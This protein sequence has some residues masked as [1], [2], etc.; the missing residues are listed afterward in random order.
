M[1]KR[2]ISILLFSGILV[3]THGQFSGGNGSGVSI[4]SLTNNAC[5]YLTNDALMI[6]KGGNG[7]GIAKVNMIPNA[8]TYLTDDALMIFKGGNGGGIA[9]VNMIPNACTFTQDIGVLIF[10]GGNGSGA[11]SVSISSTACP[12]PEANNIFLGGISSSSINGTVINTASANTTGPFI[13]TINDTTIANGNC[14]T[15]TTTGTGANTFSWT[16][17]VGLSNASTQNPIANPTETTTY[18]VTATGPSLGC[19]DVAKVTIKV[20]GAGVNTTISYPAKVCTNV[21]TIQSP[22]LT[23]ITGGTFTTTNS[24]LKIDAITGAITPNTSSVGVYTVTYTYGTCNNQVTTSVEITNDC[25]T[26]IGVIEFPN[27]YAGGSAALLSP[28]SSLVQGACTPNLDYTQLIYK[29][30][31]A[32]NLTPKSVLVQLACPIPVGDNFYLGGAGVGYGNGSLTPTTNT[33]TGTAVAVSADI[34]ICPGV[35]TTLSATGASFYS[36]T[37]SAGLSNTTSANPIASPSTTTT[38]TVLGSG[39]GVGC[40]NTAKVTVT[41]IADPSTTVSYGGYNFDEEDLNLK[42]V[43]YIN[44]PLTGTFSY[45]PTGLS[46]NASDG[47]FTPGLS[48]SGIYAINYAYTKGACSYVATTNI[49]ITKLPPTITYTNPAR[50]Y[51][52]YNG[53]TLTPNITG[54]TAVIFEILDVLPTGLTFNTLTGV[55]SGTP[56]QLVDNLPIRVRAAN[57]KR[58]Q[59]INWG[60]IFTINLSVKQPVINIGNT[61]I[62]SLNTTYGAPSTTQNV[63]ITADNIIDHI[64][65]VAPVGFETS[66]YTNTGFADT[67][68]MYPTAERNIIQPLYIRLKK[69]ANVGN[70]DGDIQL[71][72]TSAVSKVITTS[73]SYVAPANLT[74]TA[75]YFQKFYGSKITLGAGSRYFTATGL[76]N[77]ETIGSVTITPSGGTAVDAPVGYYTITPSAA[78][79]GTFSSSNYNINYVA[80][81]FQVV[82]SLYNFAM[83]GT[84]S[85]WVKGIVPVP[86]MSNLLVNNITKTA[87]TFSGKVPSSYVNIESYGVCYS[88]TINPT[89]NDSK[90]INGSTVAGNFTLNLTSLIPGTR[91]FARAYVTIGNTTFYSQNIRFK[92]VDP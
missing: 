29:G 57:Y 91:Y 44:G 33:I 45:S 41:V 20:L 46:F 30:G 27:V 74:I 31:S 68:K 85:N 79:S 2:F 35:S 3:T 47:S 58:D 86:K 51:F 25:S 65:V 8:C 69:T 82:Y 7:G 63:S 60:E 42:K 5:T 39:P 17:N 48:T 49:N 89:I 90:Q 28:N 10:K 19:R 24:G 11:N 81:Q 72:S 23:G 43:R 73:T 66:V 14:I 34:T 87:A 12:A 61:T 38:Y 88:T 15:L 80:G 71:T 52:N 78:Y 76:M 18:T 62:S 40:I 84:G 75:K 64:L 22:I 50:F 67:I 55:I 92:T 83:T 59:S 37:P 26:N 16:P 9:K 4:H 70:H 21:T 6:F 36:W 54:G 13:A 32:S 56:T 77:N 53:V 1:F